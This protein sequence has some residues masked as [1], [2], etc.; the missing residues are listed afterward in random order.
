MRARLQRKSK[1]ETLEVPV[2]I[3]RGA[4]SFHGKSPKTRW[5]DTVRAHRICLKEIGGGRLLW[6]I[7][8]LD[9]APSARG[10]VETVNA[11]SSTLY[12]T[13]SG[14]SARAGSGPRKHRPDTR[15][16]NGSKSAERP[17]RR[18]PSDAASL[19]PEPHI[20]GDLEL[21]HDC[22]LPL[23]GVLR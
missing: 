14:K 6:S 9:S 15:R 16:R 8:K 5:I 11:W 22:A 12:I 10:W 1:K 4:F 20:F 19:P 2:G 23:S 21:A 17:A 18:G 7:Y 3:R 13:H